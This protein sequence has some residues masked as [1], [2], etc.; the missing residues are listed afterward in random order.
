MLFRSVGLVSTQSNENVRWS[1]SITDIAVYQFVL[2]QE[3]I[4]A[5]WSASTYA[6][7]I[8]FNSDRYTATVLADTPVIWYRLNE[9][10]NSSTSIVNSS[11]GGA[12]F[13]ANRT[14]LP[15]SVVNAALPILNYLPSP[16]VPNAGTVMFDGNG[17]IIK[18]DVA[19]LA[20][21]DQALEIG[22]A[23]V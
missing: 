1:G 16:T 10:N 23:H 17:G 11:S 22:R 15:G 13:N 3:A 5:H 9:T 8:S 4:W 20:S 7:T 21:S 18:L 2:S 6:P 14:T 12:T 19:N